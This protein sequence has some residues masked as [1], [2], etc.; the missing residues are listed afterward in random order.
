MRNRCRYSTPYAHGG[1][2]VY[3]SSFEVRKWVKHLNDLT[4]YI[5]HEAL[6]ST[7]VLYVT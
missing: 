3:A 5:E 2:S 1:V 4:E 6:R 7:G